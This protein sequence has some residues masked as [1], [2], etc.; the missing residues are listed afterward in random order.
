MLSLDSLGIGIAYG[1]KGVKIPKNAKLIIFAVSFLS[2]TASAEFGK[3]LSFSFPNIF[4]KVIGFIILVGIGVYTA[5]CDPFTYD[6][7]KSDKIEQ[8]EAFLMGLALSADVAGV[9]IGSTASGLSTCCLPVAAS[10]CQLLALSIGELAGRHITKGKINSGRIWT[11]TAGI[12][13]IVIGI[14]RI[15]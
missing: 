12:I 9:V 8:K 7:D 15:V 14:L 13:I 5:F 11:I 6:T 2:A 4:G 3:Y 10:I 1:I